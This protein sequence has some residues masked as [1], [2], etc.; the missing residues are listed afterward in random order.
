VT[1]Y[2]SGPNAPTTSGT[3]TLQ[4]AF[5]GFGPF[6]GGT[7]VPT[8]VVASIAH[9]LLGSTYQTRVTILYTTYANACGYET[10]ALYKSGGTIAEVSFVIQSSTG[11]PTVQ[12]GT[13]SVLAGTG[14]AG[15]SPEQPVPC[16]GP[17][18]G[19]TSDVASVTITAAGATLTGTYAF[20]GVQ[21]ATF[22]APVCNAPVVDGGTPGFCCA[23]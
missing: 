6:D 23:P 11:Y 10:N 13:Y 21:H 18:A 2:A 16:S 8:D 3:G 17:T 12:P 1:C 15:C 14:A 22:D 4:P 20:N 9:S 7:F 19:T 5:C